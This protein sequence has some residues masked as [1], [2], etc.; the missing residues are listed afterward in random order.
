MSL[1]DEFYASL[2]ASSQIEFLET[3]E[4]ATAEDSAANTASIDPARRNR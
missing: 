3:A 2:G 4:N 1:L